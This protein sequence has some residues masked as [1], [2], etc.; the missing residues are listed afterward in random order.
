MVDIIDG[1]KESKPS[2]EEQTNVVFPKNE[3]KLI[4]FLNRCK[5]KE[6]KVMMCPCCNAFVD[7]EVAK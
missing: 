3:E 6:S 4:D 7:N 5:L 1:T 2:Y